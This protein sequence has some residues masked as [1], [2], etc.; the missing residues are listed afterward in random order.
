MIKKFGQFSP[1]WKALRALQLSS[2]IARR[3]EQESSRWSP[4]HP[5]HSVHKLWPPSTIS[6]ITTP[7]WLWSGTDRLRGIIQI[8]KEFRVS[9]IVEILELLPSP[10]PYLR[11]VY[12][13][14]SC[15]FCVSILSCRHK[16]RDRLLQVCKPAVSMY[17]VLAGWVSLEN[18]S[19]DWNSS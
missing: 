9:M 10:F 15:P 12:W 5:L 4:A 13:S 19:K 18:Y 3:I 16:W 2:P 14:I 7:S 6:T 8:C 1:F 17:L 11:S